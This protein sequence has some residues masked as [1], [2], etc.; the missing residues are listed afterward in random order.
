M[1]DA[2]VISTENASMWSSHYL[3]FSIL[4]LEQLELL[5]S[6]RITPHPLPMITH[7]TDSYQIPRIQNKTKSKSQ[8]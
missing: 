4:L 7:T 8:I 2:K 6:E 1:N 5:H 3:S